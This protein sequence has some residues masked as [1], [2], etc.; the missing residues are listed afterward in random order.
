MQN[1]MQI[2]G[3]ESASTCKCRE[4]MSVTFF[5]SGCIEG[6]DPSEK[7]FL[8][9]PE[10]ENANAAEAGIYAVFT[11]RFRKCSLTS[12]MKLWNPRAQMYPCGCSVLVLL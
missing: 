3:S 12:V 1:A 6:E 4:R 7:R 8:E 5:F 9:S 11:L 10:E 2:S